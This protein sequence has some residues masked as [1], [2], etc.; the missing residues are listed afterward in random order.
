MRSI[1]PNIT[2]HVNAIKYNDIL[3]MKGNNL[4]VETIDLNRIVDPNFQ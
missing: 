2:I 4:V 3:G 1:Q